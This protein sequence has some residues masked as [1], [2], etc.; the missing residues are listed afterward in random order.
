MPEGIQM[1][2]GRKMNSGRGAI[3]V[4]SAC[5]SSDRRRRTAVSA[6]KPVPMMVMRFMV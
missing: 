6:A 5:G 3:T 4:I 2:L 1:R